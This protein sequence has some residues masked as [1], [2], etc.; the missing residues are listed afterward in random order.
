MSTSLY[1]D[2]ERGHERLLA[3]I[4]QRVRRSGHEGAIT[5]AQRLQQCQVFL[6]AG[7]TVGVR[8]ALH[9]VQQPLMHVSILPLAAKDIKAF[10]APL[11]ATGLRNWSVFPHEFNLYGAALQLKLHQ[12]LLFAASRPAPAVQRELGEAAVRLDMPLVQASVFAHEI[13]LGPSV[14][15]GYTACQASYQVRL[16]ANY[17]R[18]DVPQARDTF[19]DK[20]PDFEFKGQLEAIDRMAAALAASELERLLGG[21]RPP[22]ALSREIVVNALTQARHDSFVPYLEW[23]PVCAGARPGRQDSGFADFVAATVSAAAALAP[24]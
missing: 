9:L 2:C 5:P 6:V 18:K 3:E 17:G 16:N 24:A 11:R 15:P 22:L 13:L 10:D 8:T 1:S 20:N 14:L 23:C 19:L 12:A 7:G 4:D 21:S